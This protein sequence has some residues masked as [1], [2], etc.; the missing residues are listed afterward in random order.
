M[1][2]WNTIDYDNNV[3]KQ[4]IKTLPYHH[5]LWKNHLKKNNNQEKDNEKHVLHKDQL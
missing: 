2:Y 4:I 1:A 3:Y 5:L